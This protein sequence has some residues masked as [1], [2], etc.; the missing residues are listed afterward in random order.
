[1]ETVPFSLDHVRT[2]QAENPT[3]FYVY[4]ERGIRGNFQQLCDTFLAFLVIVINIPK[5][6][7]FDL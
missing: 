4:D 2:I 1:M 3:P 7:H 5:I 6:L